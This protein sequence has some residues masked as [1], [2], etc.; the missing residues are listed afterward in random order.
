MSKVNVMLRF[1]SDIKCYHSIAMT[2]WWILNMQPVVSNKSK[3][4]SS[5]IPLWHL[6]DGLRWVRN[7]WCYSWRDSGRT[8]PRRFQLIVPK[9]RFWVRKMGNFAQVSCEFHLFNQCFSGSS[10]TWTMAESDSRIQHIET[11]LLS[12][13][14]LKSLVTGMFLERSYNDCMFRLRIAAVC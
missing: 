8:A 3:K 4:W 9:K 11:F 5:L 10:F 2:F 13:N 7:E 6:A 14:T 1:S 12:A